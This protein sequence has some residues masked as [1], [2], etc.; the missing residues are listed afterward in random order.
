MANNCFVDIDITTASEEDAERLHKILTAAK[1]DADSRGE[2]FFIGCEKRYMFEAEIITHGNIV[3]VNGWVKWGFED[4]EVWK[5]LAWLMARAR[6]KD[7]RMRYDEGG[8]L[9]Y[10]EYHY[11]L[12]I[13]TDR[14]LPQDCFPSGEHDDVDTEKAW[15]QHGVVRIVG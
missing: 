1:K 11:D 10:G 2:G 6:V 13:L 12:K 9:L 7:F 8:C 14:Y 3:S 4:I 5:F 15:E